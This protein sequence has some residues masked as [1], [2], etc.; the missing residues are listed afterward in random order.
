MRC[1]VSDLMYFS[2]TLRSSMMVFGGF[3]VSLEGP[4]PYSID[5]YE[6]HYIICYVRGPCSELNK[7][8]PE[9]S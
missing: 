1:I 7:P 9:I 3:L 2:M 5:Y 6:D 8:P 4:R